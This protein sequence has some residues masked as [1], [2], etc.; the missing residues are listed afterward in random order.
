[1][2]ELFQLIKNLF[3]VLLNITEIVLLILEILEEKKLHLWSKL[4]YLLLIRKKFS[5]S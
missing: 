2:R 4:R 3:Q 1:M 5:I